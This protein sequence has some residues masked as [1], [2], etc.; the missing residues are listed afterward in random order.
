MK[1]IGDYIDEGFTIILSIICGLIFCFVFPIVCG[2]I[3]VIIG[4]IFKLKWLK[5]NYGVILGFIVSLFLAIAVFM[6]LFEDFKRKWR[7]RKSPHVSSGSS[8]MSSINSGGF[9]EMSSQYSSGEMPDQNNETPRT[10]WTLGKN[11]VIEGGD[12]TKKGILA[13]R[14]IGYV[15]DSLFGGT[16]LRKKGWISDEVIG[17]VK[18]DFMGDPKEIVDEHGNTIVTIKTTLSGRKIMVDSDGEEVG[19]YKD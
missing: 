13:D 4:L 18:K 9:S 10:E 2:I 3:F 17:T 6:G 16:T 12:L 15:K 5:F 19:E 1:S 8:E 14:S 7:Q 11:L